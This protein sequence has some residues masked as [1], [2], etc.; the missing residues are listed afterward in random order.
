MKRWLRYLSFF[1]L[2]TLV[3]CGASRDEG[4]ISSTKIELANADSAIT[5][6][7]TALEDFAK[8]KEAND[9]EAI[10]TQKKTLLDAAGNL[11]QSAQKLQGLYRQAESAALKTPEER[12]K[13]RK[14][15]KSKLEQVATTI[16]NLAENDRKFKI[17]LDDATKKYDKELTDVLKRL[18]EANL[19]FASLKPSSIRAR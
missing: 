13:F 12:E 19:Q 6:M 5:T 3:G 8:A 1:V 14:D 15:N 11:L 10:S 4:L 2:G 18:Q 16:S 17:A 9:K 7:T